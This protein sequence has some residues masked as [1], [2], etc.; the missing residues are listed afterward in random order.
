[1]TLAL[2][3][4]PREWASGPVVLARLAFV[5]RTNG[6]P[7]VFGVTCRRAAPDAPPMDVSLPPR[8]PVGVVS[9]PT[10]AALTVADRFPHPHRRPR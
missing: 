3:A 2:A 9:C 4:L 8:P 5:L 1:M 10:T 7:P 6:N